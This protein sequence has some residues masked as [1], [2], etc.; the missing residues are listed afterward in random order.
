VV[1]SAHVV[2]TLPL[3]LSVYGYRALDEDLLWKAI[4]QH[5]Y[6]RKLKLDSECVRISDVTDVHNNC[7]HKWKSNTWPFLSIFDSIIITPK[8]MEKLCSMLPRLIHLDAKLI[9]KDSSQFECVAKLKGLRTLKLQ[10]SQKGAEVGDH[11]NSGLES[12]KALSNLKRIQLKYFPIQDKDFESLAQLTT[13]ESLSLCNTLHFSSHGVKHL[14]RLTN[15]RTLVLKGY[16]GFD[17]EAFASLCKLI[18]L[19]KLQFGDNSLYLSNAGIQKNYG[20]KEPSHLG[21]IS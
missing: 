9:M 1:D 10:L 12:L 7:F 20:I 19:T 13:L 15:L 5:P 21:D 17:D 14:S 16:M 3:T 4:S 8:G 18:H 11:D 6:I 2:K